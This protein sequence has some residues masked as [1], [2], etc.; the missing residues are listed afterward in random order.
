MT[1]Q[2]DYI[3]KWILN[4]VSNFG[5]ISAQYEFQNSTETHFVKIT[6]PYIVDGEMYNEELSEMIIG[7]EDTFS[8]EMICFLG[9]TSLTELENPI[10]LYA[11]QEIDFLTFFN[12]FDK[13]FVFSPEN[14]TKYTLSADNLYNYCLDDVFSF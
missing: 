9:N 11:Q 6:P 12:S 13:P 2:Q 3:E 7:F 4:N 5:I 14:L 1:K 10:K 8:D